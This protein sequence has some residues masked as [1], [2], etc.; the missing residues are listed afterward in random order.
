[1]SSERIFDNKAKV[2][3]KHAKEGLRHKV[4][5]SEH[6]DNKKGRS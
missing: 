1:M 3:D 6:R 5:L 4:R 2:M